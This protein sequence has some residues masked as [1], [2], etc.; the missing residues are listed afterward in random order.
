MYL[1]I[2]GQIGMKRHTGLIATYDVF[3]YYYVFTFVYLYNRL[4][5]TYDVFELKQAFVAY[6][7]INVI[8]SNIRCI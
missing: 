6:V 2:N 8:N 7:G 3:E 5:A 4:I 1:N